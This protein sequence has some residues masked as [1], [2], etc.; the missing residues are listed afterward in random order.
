MT[1]LFTKISEEDPMM[2]RSQ[3][4]TS[5]FSLGYYVTIAMVIFSISSHVKDKNNI[6]TDG[7]EDIS[8]W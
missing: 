4:N 6:F 5:K 3:S 7:D 8:F 1:T 2:F